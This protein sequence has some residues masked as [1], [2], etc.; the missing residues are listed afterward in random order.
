MAWRVVCDRCG[1]DY[2]DHQTRTEWNG[3]RTCRGPGTN[4]CF[5]HRHP[6]DRVRAVR[7]RQAPAWTRPE[8]TDV[9]VIEYR[10]DEDGNVL[11]QDNG[12]PY[13][14]NAAD[15]AA[16]LD[17]IGSSA[18]F[19]VKAAF[20]GA[21]LDGTGA[22]DVNGFEASDGVATLD[23]AG[24]IDAIGIKEGQGT[25]DA[26]GTGAADGAGVKGGE[27]TADITGVGAATA[28]GAVIS[29]RITVPGDTRVTVGGD[30]RIVIEG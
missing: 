3:L 10:R 18:A 13:L 14:A 22:I 19:G 23:A 27:G 17:G 6:Q 12:L 30:R 21:T 26:T 25:A 8:P 20:G 24:A 4:N 9:F 11:F 16:T 29:I 2:W 28:V 5:E 7:D 15:G 1:F